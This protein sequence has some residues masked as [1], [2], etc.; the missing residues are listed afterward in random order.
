MFEIHVLRLS[1]CAAIFSPKLLYFFTP[2]AKC[3][4]GIYDR[5]WC[6]Y[7]LVYVGIYYVCGQKNLN[8]NLAI[9]LPFQIFTV[10]LMD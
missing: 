6:P 5:A 1:H 8:R 4:W 9:D 7:I 3:E 10:G 2:H